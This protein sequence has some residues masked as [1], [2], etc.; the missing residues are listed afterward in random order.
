MPQMSP[1]GTSTLV[2]QGPGAAC[3][4]RGVRRVGQGMQTQIHFGK[5]SSD[6][7]LSRAPA[8]ALKGH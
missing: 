6:L 2:P 1:K 4:A 3:K 5:H 7:P 8:V